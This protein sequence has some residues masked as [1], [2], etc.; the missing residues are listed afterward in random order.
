MSMGPSIA[1][2][3]CQCVEAQWTKNK[4]FGSCRFLKMMAEISCCE[5]STNQKCLMLQT[6]PPSFFPKQELFGGK[7]MSRNLIQTLVHV[8][9]TNSYKGSQTQLYTLGQCESK[10]VTISTFLV[11][12]HSLW[13]TILALTQ[14]VSD[15]CVDVS[16]VLGQQWRPVCVAVVFHQAPIQQQ[17]TLGQ[18]TLGETKLLIT[19]VD[20]GGLRP[21]R[22]PWTQKCRNFTL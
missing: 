21:Q 18:T 1:L 17:L 20:W 15:G 12:K 13:V 8:V 3:S 4:L 11:R 10:K 9:E 19:V 7:I 6:T 14:Q 22:L 16:H 5:W 2:M